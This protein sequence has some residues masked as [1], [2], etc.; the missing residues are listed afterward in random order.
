MDSN[1][2]NWRAKVIGDTKYLDQI[3]FPAESEMAIS[4]ECD[5]ATADSGLYWM[6]RET[7]NV[8]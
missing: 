4:W 1:G 5:G 7:Y 8:I 2:V 3:Y 6:W